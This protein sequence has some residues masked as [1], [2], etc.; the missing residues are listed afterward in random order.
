MVDPSAP[1]P[2]DVDVGAVAHDMRN[3]LATILMNL[4]LLK[5]V[6]ATGDAERIGKHIE[7]IGRA[8]EKMQALVAKLRGETAE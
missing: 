7:V 5:R 8:A 3:A 1:K 2:A 4:T 6:S